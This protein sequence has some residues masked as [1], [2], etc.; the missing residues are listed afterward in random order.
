MSHIR[1]FLA[2]LE[3]GAPLSSG[4]LTIY[5]LLTN[6]TARPGY[7]TLDQAL[8]KGLAHV[9][10]VGE[11]GSVPDLLFRNDGDLPVL[12]LDGEELVGAKQNRILNLTI[13]VPAK[14]TLKIPVSCVERN[15]WSYRS[16]HFTSSDRAYNARGR[17]EK[18]GQVAAAMATVGAPR[19]NQ[20][21]V[22]ANVAA[23]A[24]RAQVHSPTAA[25]SDVYE[26]QR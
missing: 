26:Q 7:L 10:E 1:D 24:S 8:A 15:R 13:L 2:D 11:A 12:L 9:S 23:T 19:S 14:T 25:M 22:W 16:R 17:A 3:I 21:S 4:R 18:M 5:P 6:R 20:Q